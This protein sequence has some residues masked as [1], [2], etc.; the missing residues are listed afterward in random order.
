MAEHNTPLINEIIAQIKQHP[1]FESWKTR[2]SAPAT[3]FDKLADSLRSDPRFKSHPQRLVASAGRVVN[4]MF[5]SWLAIHKGNFARLKGKQRWLAMLKSD[6]ELVEYSGCDLVQIRNHAAQILESIANSVPSQT[7]N[8]TQKKSTQKKSSR[9]KSNQKDNN[10][11]NTLYKLYDST[12]DVMAQAAIIYLLKN[13]SRVSDCEEDPEKFTQKYRKTELQVERLQ[14]QID[15]NM[16]KGRDLTGKVWEETLEIAT[17]TAPQNGDEAKEWQNILLRRPKNTPYPIFY[18]NKEDLRWSEIEIKGK[19]RRRGKNHNAPKKQLCVTLSGFGGHV[20]KVSCDR[21]QLHW[22]KRFLEDQQTKKNSDGQ[23]SSSL[24]TLRSAQLLWHEQKGNG[25]SWD[26]HHLHLHCTV[27]TPRWTAEGTEKIRQAERQEVAN[28]IE[29]LNQKEAL[30]PSQQK[31]LQRLDSQ[32][33]G[34][35][36]PFDRPSRPLYTPQPDIIAAVSMGL[37]YPATLIIMNSS[38]QEVLATRTIR[39][40]LGSN[41]GLLLRRRRQQQKNA[42]QRHKAQKRSASD[43]FGESNLGE[44]LDRLIAKEIVAIAKAHKAQSIVI[45]KLARIRE[46]LNCEVMSRAEQRCPG[47]VEIQ[48]RY[49][50]EYRTKIHRWSYS[51]LISNIQV[52]A[53]KVGILLEEAEQSFQGTQEEKAKELAIAAYQSRKV[54]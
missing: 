52:Q 40:L 9:K 23:C 5:E 47:S 26:V 25:N 7:S 29:S 14:K 11:P 1:D 42:H 12:D 37:Q 51:R 19:A 6:E 32:L 16:P 39:E 44:Y 50:K 4:S 41:Y 53:K 2:G 20:L 48:K 27:E 28:R 34:L 13:G 33:K 30:S 54:K 35:D 22:F 36:Y 38:T 8:P 45:P 15:A 21:R 46:I 43:Q 24:F 3:A 31:Y 10:I 18:R 17:L 49:A